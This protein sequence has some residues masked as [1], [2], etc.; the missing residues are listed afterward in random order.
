MRVVLADLKSNRGFVSKDT[1]VGGYGSRLDPFSR[2]TTVM[3]YLKKTVSRRAERAHGVPRGD[4]GAR[5]PRGELDARRA[6]RRR[7][8]ARA[9][10]ARRLQERDGVGRSDARRAASRSASSASR[11]RRCRSC[12]PITATSSSNGE[13]EAARDAAG[14]GRSSRRASSS[15][16]RSTISIRCRSRAG[17]WSPRTASRARASSG[18]SRPVGG[19]YPAAR[20]PRLPGVLH[21][22]PAPDPRRLPRALDREHRR[23]A[24]AAVRPASAAVRHLPRSAVHRAARPRA[25]SCA[26]RSRRAA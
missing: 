23:R 24:R 5:R 1:V 25:S 7:R 10:V 18:S 21:L 8:R 20:E 22:L 13:P 14:A 6:G 19:G 16:S 3:A 12:S 11:R 17:I 9:V 26:T 2:V 15:A 4:P